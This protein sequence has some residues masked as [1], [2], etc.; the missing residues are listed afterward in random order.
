MRLFPEVDPQN[1]LLSPPT[2]IFLTPKNLQLAAG[3]ENFPLVG[4]EN[5][6][7]VNL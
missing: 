6:F 3:M 4:A 2:S 5:G 1:S 7:L